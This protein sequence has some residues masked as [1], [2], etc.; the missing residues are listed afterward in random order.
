M[1]RD[2]GSRP[3]YGLALDVVEPSAGSRKR[4][5]GDNL[6]A[7]VDRDIIFDLSILDTY[8]YEGWKPIHYDLLLACAAVEFADR[9]C[10][11]RAGRWSRSFRVTLPVLEPA[12]WRQPHVLGNLQ[13][14]LNHLTGDN[15][16]FCFVQATGPVENGTRQRTLPFDRNKEFAIAYSDGLDSRCVSGIF[17]TDG[18]AV[19]VRLTQH[20]DPIKDGERPFDRIPFKVKVKSARESNVRSRGF[21]F[22]AIG[23]VAAHLSNLT[24]IIVPESGQD[25]LGPVL[26]PLH[27]VYPD[28]RNH[29][30][31]FRR[32]E[33]FIKGLLEYSVVYEQPRLWHTKGETIRDYLALPGTRRESV[34]NT[35]SCWQQRWNA[36]LDG[37]RRQCGLCAACLLRRMSMN[38]AEVRE[39]AD[40][41]TFGDLTAPSYEAAIPRGDGLRLSRSMLEYGI[42]GARHLQRLAAMA[43]WP[44]TALRPYVF[45]IAHATGL[46]EQETCIALRRLLLE[47]AEEWRNFDSAQGPR[48]FMKSWTEGARN[49]RPK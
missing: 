30:A 23:A 45:E 2:Q 21:K 31:F 33:R 26:L 18:S 46:P 47:H 12:A 11:R 34:L 48:S 1:T 41:Y 36:R 28:Y 15:W 6:V 29:P 37:K 10:R 17:D 25:A 16:R 35:R 22:A 43:E 8:R 20:K 40:T 4:S 7:Q 3:P 49:A 13:D 32:M 39:P 24:K 42:V 27:N 19:R 44:D 14:T 5:K 9:R 38:A